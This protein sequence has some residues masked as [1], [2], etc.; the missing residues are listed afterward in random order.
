MKKPN[1]RTVFQV[2][3]NPETRDFRPRIHADH[4]D[5]AAVP[6]M[7]AELIKLS[8]KHGKETH[9]ITPLADDQTCYRVIVAEILHFL[10][11]TPK[12][13]DSCDTVKEY[14][15]ANQTGSA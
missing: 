13:L 8:V 5:L 10:D 4:E 15:L 14:L 2:E 9:F 3:I 11:T 1:L 6:L 12:Q 7:L